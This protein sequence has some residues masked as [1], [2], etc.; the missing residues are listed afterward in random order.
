MTDIITLL[1]LYETKLKIYCDAIYFGGSRV[2]PVIINPQDFDYICFTKPLC[3]HHLLR[4]L[5]KE[6]YRVNGS[7]KAKKIENKKYSDFSQIR[8]YPYTQITW[9]SYLDSLMYR[10]VGE[11][12]CPKTDI[13]NEHKVAFLK[14]LKEKAILILNDTIKNKKRW[15]HILRGVYILKNSSYEVSERQKQEIN[16]LHDLSEGWELISDKTI[17]LLNE[18]LKTENLDQ[19]IV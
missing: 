2:D 18:L 11:D 3:K 8:V 1:N 12:V 5:F 15:Y 14:A 10:V 19:I 17:L 4:L 9:F 7:K 16:I 13:I 6:G